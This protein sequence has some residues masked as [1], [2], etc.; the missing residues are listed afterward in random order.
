MKGFIS[1]LRISFVGGGTDMP[2]YYKKY[3]GEVITTAINKYTWV[4][5]NKWQNKNLLLK[6][7][8]SEL[9]DNKKKIKHRLIREIMKSYNFTGLDINFIADLP[10]R[11]GL[12]S[13]SSF[14]VALIGALEKFKGEKINKK[15]LAKAACDIEI[16]KLKDPIGKQDQYI[17]AF[18][19]LCHIIFKKDNVFVKK[20]NI[21]K[22]NF[23]NFEKSISLINTGIFRSANKILKKQSKK[24]KRNEHIYHE[25]RSLVPQF[26]FALKNNDIKKC[27]NIL[28]E[29]WNLKKKLDDNVYL[30]KFSLIEKKLNKLGVYGYKLLGAGSGGYYCV[31]SSQNQK[32]K[33]KKIF[34]KKFL[35][36]KFDN[37][38]AREVKISI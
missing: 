1:P 32:K 33:L 37:L 16:K 15:K 30:K 3:R 6:Y 2:F 38:G 24:A 4:L 14:T 17:S 35:N 31:I 9:V 25:I 26:L 36:I 12:G 27:G 22:K 5:I 8:K 28:K 21:E 7:S 20:I 29:N 10:N 23:L 19:G 11:A 34:K 18:G 13:S